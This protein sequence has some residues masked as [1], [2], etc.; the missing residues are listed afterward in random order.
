M[1]SGAPIRNGDRHVGEIALLALHL[2]QAVA[3]LEIRHR[4][5]ELFQIRIGIHSGEIVA[6]VVG[7]FMPR[8]K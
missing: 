1:V 4:P 3:K 5:G 6:G 8:L 7:L 2:L